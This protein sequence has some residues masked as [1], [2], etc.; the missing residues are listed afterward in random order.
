MKKLL[1]IVLAMVLALSVGLVGCGGEGEGEGEPAVWNTSIPVNMHLTVPNSFVSVANKTY[2]PWANEV[3]NHTGSL[4]GTFNITI[5]WANSPYGSEDSLAG[6]STGLSDIGQ[7]SGDTYDLGGIGYLPFMYPNVS[8][9]V[10]AGYTILRDE[11]ATWD[12]LAQLRDVRILLVTPLHGANW[13]GVLP[14]NVTQPGDLA[15]LRVRAE[16]GEVPTLQALNATPK[17][18]IALSNLAGQLSGG[19]VD[20]A[21][22]TYSAMLSYGLLAPI[23][24]TT[25]L[26]LFP[27]MYTLACN[28]DW[29]DS[30]PSEAQDWLGNCTTMARSLYYAAIH[31]GA[32]NYYK[33]QVAA[34]LTASGKPPIYVVN[35]SLLDPWINATAGVKTTWAADM[36]YKGYTGAALLAE[37]EALVA[38]AP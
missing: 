14:F 20:G 19:Y 15:G 33:G 5:T 22:V 26:G 32:V 11:V 2:V 27:R 38:A 36:T 17:T 23:N 37:I 21:F 7:L 8:S 25:Q 13:I 4:G 12:K 10:Y 31:E 16:P 29:Y 34:N 9:L 24:Y 35:G 30:L 3:M 6:I 28:K 18:N 1:F